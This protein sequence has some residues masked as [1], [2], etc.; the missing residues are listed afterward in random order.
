M[1]TMSFRSLLILPLV[2]G[3]YACAQ[4]QAGNPSSP[5]VAS[6]SQDGAQVGKS[7]RLTAVVRFGRPDTG[8]PFPPV[9]HTIIP[10]TRKT[11]SRRATS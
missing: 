1:R 7:T 5:S 2:V 11:T 3:L 6:L 10:G 4:W 9:P 8:S